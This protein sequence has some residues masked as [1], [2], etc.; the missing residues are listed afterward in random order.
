MSHVCWKHV[1]S[2]FSQRM[3]WGSY[4]VAVSVESLV[5]GHAGNPHFPT[6]IKPYTSRERTRR[7]RKVFGDVPIM[8]TM[9]VSPIGGSC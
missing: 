8:A 2:K 4:S 7:E 5:S 3:D 6:R 1:E 9:S